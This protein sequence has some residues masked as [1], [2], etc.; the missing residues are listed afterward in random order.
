MHSGRPARLAVP[1][2]SPFHPSS[3]LPCRGSDSPCQARGALQA[4][5]DAPAERAP[6]GERGPLMAPLEGRSGPRAEQLD[7]RC[8]E[9]QAPVCEGE[10]SSSF[11]SGA[12]LRSG[13]AAPAALRSVGGRLTGSPSRAIIGGI[14]GSNADGSSGDASV[15]CYH[16]GVHLAVGVDNRQGAL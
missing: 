10:W 12:P 8:I 11:R 13:P 2:H 1:G 16:C 9:G 5:A 7:C 4:F 6:S 3:T 14:Q 15:I